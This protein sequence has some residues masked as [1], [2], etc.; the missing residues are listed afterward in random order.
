VCFV[1]LKNLAMRYLPGLTLHCQRFVHRV[2]VGVSCDPVSVSNGVPVLKCITEDF[3]NVYE[4]KFQYV[5][6]F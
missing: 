4:N 5:Q 6:L 2:P 1:A 3:T